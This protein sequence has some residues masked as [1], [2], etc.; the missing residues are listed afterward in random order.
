M[1]YDDKEKFHN[2]LKNVSKNLKRY[3]SFISIQEIEEIR[4]LEDFI[5]DRYFKIIEKTELHEQHQRENKI[6]ISKYVPVVSN[7]EATSITFEKHRT[8]SDMISPIDE[9]LY[10]DFIDMMVGKDRKSKEVKFDKLMK[11]MPKGSVIINDGKYKWNSDFFIETYKVAQ[12]KPQ[13]YIYAFFIICL[14]EGYISLEE[15]SPI[16]SIREVQIKDRISITFQ[17]KDISY[18]RFRDY[19]IIQMKK[20]KIHYFKPFEGLISSEKVKKS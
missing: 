12:N 16:K 14:D 6:I 4:P 7:L 9:L 20:D 5:R 2:Y 11:K 1:R 18:R 19:E 10:N 3:F 15:L 8:E 13:N 17:E